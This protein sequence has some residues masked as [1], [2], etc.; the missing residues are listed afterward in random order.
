MALRAIII[1]DDEVGIEA[2]KLLIEKFIGDVKVVAESSDPLHAIKLI[3]DYSPD[4]IFLDIQ[5]PGMNGFELLSSFPE[6][7]FHLIFTT[8]HHQHALRALKLNPSDYLLKPV[9]YKELRVAIDKIRKQITDKDMAL[10]LEYEWINKIP[11]FQKNRL[12]VTTRSGIESIELAD[13]ISFESMSN[14][15]RIYLR[16]LKTLVTPKTL[17]EFELQLCRGHLNFMRVHNSYVI[18]LENVVR[19][20]KEEESIMMNNNQRIPIARSRKELFFKWLD[21]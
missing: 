2:L 8:A 5:M 14:Y 1:D 17:K 18:N 7:N 13:I 9:D 19:Y 6:K 20:L 10:K 21:V 4:V 15:T 3:N 16:E 12:V 11:A